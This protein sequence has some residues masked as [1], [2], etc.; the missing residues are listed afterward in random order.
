MKS[1]VNFILKKPWTFE[2]NV[3]DKTVNSDIIVSFSCRLAQHILYSLS[4]YAYEHFNAIF[5]ERWPIKNRFE[6][7]AKIGAWMIRWLILLC[8]AIITLS[9][10]IASQI[11]AKR[12][13]HLQTTGNLVTSYSLV[14]NK[15]SFR[16]NLVSIWGSLKKLRPNQA[17]HC[18]LRLS[19]ETVKSVISYLNLTRTLVPSGT[20]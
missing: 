12:R 5:I 7:F 18:T 6:I 20:D 13:E 3:Y 9:T 16:I 17:L 4:F 10:A 8:A 1:T 11:R 19:E 2:I 15:S 14:L